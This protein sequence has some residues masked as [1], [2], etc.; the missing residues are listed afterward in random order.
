PGLTVEDRIDVKPAET[1]R[2][3]YTREMAREEVNKARTQK[4]SVGDSLDDA[5]I[6]SK[7][8]AKLITD[9]KT[10]ES[11]INVDV[12]HNGVTLRGTVDTIQAKQEAERV[13]KDTDGV[14][15]VNNMLKVGK[16]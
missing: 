7:I 16:S 10:P 1:A 3:D 8:V 15:R 5:W 2:A 4:E 14:K 6:H 9:S 11:K 13:A 12:D